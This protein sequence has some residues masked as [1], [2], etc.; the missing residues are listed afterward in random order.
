MD[1]VGPHGH[2]VPFPWSNEP[3]S[4]RPLRPYLWSKFV[5]TAKKAHFQGQTT[6]GAVHGLFDDLEFRPYFEQKFLWTSVKTLSMEPVDPH[7]QNVPFSRSK[8]PRRR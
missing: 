1:P 7:G 3:H 6:P 8:E 5:I 2:N 4:R